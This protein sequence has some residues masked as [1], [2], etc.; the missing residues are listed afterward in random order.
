MRK[1]Y[2]C[3]VFVLASVVLLALAG[4]EGP[5]GPR[6]PQ[7][8]SGV[9][10][11]M[12]CHGED[13]ALI[14]IAAQWANSVHATGGNF[15]RN[16]PPCSG[17]HTHEGFIARLATGSP[18][19]PTNPSSIHCFTCHAPHT[20]GDFR[21]RTDAPVNLTLGGVFDMGHGNLCAN[22]HQARKP[23]PVVAHAPDSTIIGNA[24]WGPHHSAQ[25]SMLSGNGGYEFAGYEYQDSPHAHVVINGCPSCHMATPFGALAGGHSMNMTHESEGS[26]IDL[27]AGCNA[28]D[29][30]WGAVTD[31]SFA[32]AQAE[33]GGLL[34]ELH[35]AL[36]AGG[37]IDS[38]G[39][40]VPG[41]Y[42][43]AEAGALYNFLFVD[44]DRSEGIHNT[45]YAKALL[46]ASLT[47]LG[48]GT[49][50]ALN[51]VSPRRVKHVSR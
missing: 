22:C 20:N 38:S 9:A 18:G 6:G 30:H 47:E 46:E 50:V 27:V 49:P 21:L 43:E 39:S 25:A 26:E 23:S 1:M 32:G 36:L 31:F 2:M 28:E 14:A 12:V 33:V 16:T 45:K 44:G 19:T 24:F 40:A 8:G 15:A 11:C 48:V 3:A 17:C 51:G 37:I 5:T 42:S 4:C 13:T 29:C 34:D 35:A 41:K 10:E 7:G